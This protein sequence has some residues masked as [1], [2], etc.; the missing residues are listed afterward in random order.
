MIGFY[1]FIRLS[2]F[3]AISSH[4]V[5]FFYFI[6]FKLY[7]L[8]LVAL[9]N[10][11]E[12][13]NTHYPDKQLV[14]TELTVQ[15][16]FQNEKKNFYLTQFQ[17]SGQKKILQVFH[18]PHAHLTLSSWRKDYWLYR[19]QDLSFVNGRLEINSSLL[20]E[21]FLLIVSRTGRIRVEQIP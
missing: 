19:Q 12:I 14:L 17:N 7:L 5:Y 4:F 18:L 15:E 20:N 11:V 3:L 2:A 1:V 10:F 21:Q 9:I 16:S 6:V 8:Y 13:Y